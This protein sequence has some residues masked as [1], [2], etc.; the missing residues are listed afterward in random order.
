MTTT[1]KYMSPYTDFGFKKLFGTEANKDLLIDFLNQLI[2]EQGR[3]TDITYLRNEHVGRS[4]A[5]RRAVF[6]LFCTNERGEKFIVEMQRAKQKYFKDRSVYYS[7]F[8]IQEQAM[9]GNTWDFQLKSVYFVG[10]LDFVFDEDR[11]DDEYCYYHEVKLMDVNRKNVFYDK[12]T[13]IYLEMP[14]F[15]KTEQELKTHFDKWLYAIKHLSILE[16]RP[17]KLRERVFGRLFRI[18]EIACFTP[19]EA[20][21]YEDSLKVYRDLKNV[22]DT[23]VEEAREEAREKGLKEGLQE[24][25]QKGIQEGIQKGEALGLTKGRTEEKAEVAARC[26]REGMSTEFIAKVTGLSV[27]E[28]TVILE[29]QVK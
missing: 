16:E 2:R 1:N 29:K 23:A 3:I 14:K 22:I 11:D 24:G 9:A 5:D 15:R 18:A 28:I 17:A 21:V 25:I 8:P 20:S 27:K 4:P 19:E 13:F 7:S 10:I 26:A 12:L 6:D